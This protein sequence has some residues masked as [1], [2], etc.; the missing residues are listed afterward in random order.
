MTIELFLS[1]FTVSLVVGVAVARWWI[2]LA[3]PVLLF[4]W[5]VAVAVSGG[6]NSDGMPDWLLTLYVGA[7]L[8]I[9]SICGLV[10]GVAWGKFFRERWG[11]AQQPG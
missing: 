2:V 7:F 11:R 5:V 1:I 10:L 4:V 8:G 9:F 3:A 6:E